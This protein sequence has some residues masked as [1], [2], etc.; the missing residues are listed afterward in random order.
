MRW[1]MFLG[2]KIFESILDG[3]YGRK[4]DLYNRWITRFEQQLCANP[5]QNITPADSHDRLVGTLEVR[6]D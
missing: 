6:A 5:E 2:C 3:T 4:L 1:A